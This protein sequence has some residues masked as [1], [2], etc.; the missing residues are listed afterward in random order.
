MR[1]E[2]NANEQKTKRNG[3]GVMMVLLCGG[4]LGGW[5]VKEGPAHTSRVIT[6]LLGNSNEYHASQTYKVGFFF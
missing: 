5:K 2:G 3:I 4:A 6:R 1:V